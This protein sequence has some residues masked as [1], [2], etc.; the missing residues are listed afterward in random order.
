MGTIKKTGLASWPAGREL[1]WYWVSDGSTPD[2][3]GI[4]TDKNRRL[5]QMLVQLAATPYY[6]VGG[7][8]KAKNDSVDTAGEGRPFAVGAIW[9]NGEKQMFVCTSAAPGAAV[10]LSLNGAGEASSSSS[11]SESSS[12][13]SSNSSSSNSSSSSDSSS[14]DSSSSESSSS[15][16][17]MSTSSESS[18]SSDSSSS[19]STMSSSSSSSSVKSS[20]SSSS[21]P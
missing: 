4:M 1:S 7:V 2:P 18:S 21:S 12:S 14:S 19:D 15:T 11:S 9:T 13:S 8:P 10:W 17:E 6:S 16:E 5:E 3:A 20:S